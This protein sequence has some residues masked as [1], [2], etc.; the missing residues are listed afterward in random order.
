MNKN[1]PS[2]NIEEYR[3]NTYPVGTVEKIEKK[4]SVIEKRGIGR[5]SFLSGALTAGL[6]LVF[7]DQTTNS[8][9]RNLDDII[10]T[11]M[12][13]LSEESKREEMEM[14]ADLEKKATEDMIENDIRTNVGNRMGL[15]KILEEHPLE[16]LE[17]L[18]DNWVQDN[19]KGPGKRLDL[20]EALKRAQP[21]LST[22]KYIFL[23][24]GLPEEEVFISIIESRFLNKISP[25]GARGV[26][27]LMPQ[28]VYDHKGLISKKYGY[29]V[30]DNLILSGEIAAKALK[31]NQE[32]TGDLNLARAAYNSS[33]VWDYRRREGRDFKG[34]LAY[35]GKRLKRRP[36]DFKFV[37]ENI[38]FITGNEGLKRILEKNYPEIFHVAASGDS[39]KIY[40]INREP[41][42]DIVR[43]GDSVWKLSERYLV[44]E[45]GTAT[46]HGVRRTANWIQRKTGM[47]KLIQPNQRIR[48]R[49]PRNL[50]DIEYLTGVNLREENYHIR[51]PSLDLPYKKAKIVI[52]I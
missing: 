11:R 32:V 42:T 8:R 3:V 50:K 34:Y 39:F 31:H 12:N 10:A 20:E 38:K 14:M 33:M 41:H 22:L 37:D 48:I 36:Q 35:L 15:A 21:Y 2:H 49:G 17:Y 30:R 24:N 51:N 27:Q 23:Q 26:W 46:L 1:Y 16:T 5:R 47:G 13:R 45:F 43:R 40:E 4:R 19:L 44:K 9:R 7:P 25:K 28:T 18:T 29:D 52:P 6:T